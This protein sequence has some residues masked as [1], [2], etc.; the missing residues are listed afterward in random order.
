MSVAI[1]PQP[2]TTPAPFI[3]GVARSGTTLLRFMLD[4]HPELAIPAETHF[5]PAVIA[6][7]ET[8]RT[9][10]RDSFVHRATSG[11][12]WAD[13]GL[14]KDAFS[15]AVAALETF[16]VADG[17]RTFYRLCAAA[18]HKTRWGDKTPTYA[19]HISAISA[20]LPEAHFVHIIRDGR[21]VAASRRHLSFGP[22]PEIAAQARDWCRKIRSARLQAHACPHFLEV[23][24]EDLLLDTEAVLRGIC[25]FLEL[26]F[27]PSMLDFQSAA[28][29][30]LGEF[31]DWHL[32]A[33]E[34]FMTGDY[35]RDIHSR[36]KLP[37]DA[38]RID[39]WRLAFSP[40]DVAVF[41]AE[42][43]DLL[44]ELGYPLTTQMP[45]AAT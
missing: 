1:P 33:G 39:H 44:T 8:G 35:R 6:H 4:R 11:F 25:A 12:A 13:C 9:L 22:G 30:R 19:D 43:G 34:V 3:V 17:I 42:A 14:D 7:P 5:L 45:G 10:D 18:Q 20:I 29:E 28:R 16:T 26:D 21:A 36:T 27:C 31:R 23:R 37:L 2:T 32:P 41:E 40:Q 38:G 15:S 24:Y